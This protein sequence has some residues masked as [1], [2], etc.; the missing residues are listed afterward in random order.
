MANEY[1]N[2]R[3]EDML[4]R[5]IDLERQVAELKRSLG[6][7]NLRSLDEQLKLKGLK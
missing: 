1:D 2:T 7:D 6:S 5:L 4:V 3:L